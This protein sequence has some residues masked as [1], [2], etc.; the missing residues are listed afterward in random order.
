MRKLCA[1]RREVQWS[2]VLQPVLSWLQEPHQ[3]VYEAARLHAGTH[4]SA[5]GQLLQQPKGRL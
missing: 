4:S 5:H 3:K 1:Q 2:A